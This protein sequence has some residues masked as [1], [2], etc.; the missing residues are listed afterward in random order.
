MYSGFENDNVL[1]W[2]EQSN[3]ILDTNVTWKGLKNETF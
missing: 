1:C 3:P 2:V